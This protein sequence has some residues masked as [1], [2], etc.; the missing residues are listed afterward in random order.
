MGGGIDPSLPLGR[1]CG[2]CGPGGDPVEPTINDVARHAAV[3]RTTV[4]RF[5]N[6][7]TVRRA[8]DIAA[9]IAALNFEPNPIARSLREGRTS[10]VGVIVADVANPFFAA[11]FK[12]IEDEARRH[13]ATDR[14]PV[15]LFLC[16]TEE[17]EDRLLELIDG[18]NGR[19]DGLIIA[20]PVETTPPDE[21]RRERE[22]VVLLDRVF[23]GEPFADSVL[24]DN[25]GGMRTA[26]EYLVG[27]GHR[28]I[29][30]ISG[31][32]NTTPGR[33]RLEGFVDGIRASGLP[34]DDDLIAFGD[35]R[36]P[37]G[38][39]AATRLLQLPRPPTAIISANNLM[40]LGALAQ[41][42][43]TG[44][45]LPD[46][47]SF[48]GFDDLA[49]AALLR[50]SVTTIS[51]PTRDQGAQAMRMLTQRLRGD[52]RPP[53]ELVL[54]VELHPRGSTA[55]PPG[56]PGSHDPTRNQEDAR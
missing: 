56:V 35:F 24:V 52:R 54:P 21:L 9:A 44:I 22:P 19:V 48:V 27:L 42:A 46:E 37:G 15:Q 40:S 47:L 45:Q 32:E 12:G 39:L 16:N 23:S 50:P 2:A 53:V 28:R 55:P 30:L 1:G 7:S 18:L 49:P 13:N 25:H 6:G 11:A 26:V 34:W 4:S 36:E 8:D 29:G 43:R 14:L 20:P 33:Q 5:L 31:P 3:S 38:A 51:R 10:S 41:L 17:R